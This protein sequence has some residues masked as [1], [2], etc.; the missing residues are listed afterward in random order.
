MGIQQSLFRPSAISAGPSPT[1]R[2]FDQPTSAKPISDSRSYEAIDA[3]LEQQRRRLNI[4][5]VALAIVEGNQIATEGGVVSTEPAEESDEA[6]AGE[7]GTAAAAGLVSSEDAGAGGETG[8]AGGAGGAANGAE[9]QSEST[10]T[11][12]ATESEVAPDESP[13][14]VVAAS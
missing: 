2:R 9:A 13:E 7:A 14:S 6:A 8:N 1:V 12:S 11:A 4:P 5:G 3:Y 10:T